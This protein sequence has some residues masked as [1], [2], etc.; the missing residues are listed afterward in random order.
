MLLG[1]RHVSVLL[2]EIVKYSKQDG[3]QPD[4]KTGNTSKEVI[5]KQVN[6]NIE[7]LIEKWKYR[8][9]SK[10]TSYEESEYGCL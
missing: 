9:T 3:D 4:T 7:D 1:D 6:K 5:T 8:Q 2:D 10:L